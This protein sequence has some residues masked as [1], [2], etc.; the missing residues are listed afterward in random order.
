MAASIARIDRCAPPEDGPADPAYRVVAFWFVEQSGVP[1]ADF[2]VD[3]ALRDRLGHWRKRPAETTAAL[4][5]LTS[6][7][8]SCALTMDRL[9]AAD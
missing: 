1:A 3:P 8:D 4:R 2:A 9:P 6:R 5:A 7:L